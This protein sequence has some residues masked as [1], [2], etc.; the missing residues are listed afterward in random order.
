MRIN[1]QVLAVLSGAQMR[2]NTLVITQQLD[3]A[4]YTQ[5]NKVLEAAGGKWDRKA[6][7]HLFPSDAAERM[8]Q[9]ILTGEVTIPKDEFDYFPTPAAL[10]DRMVQ[11]AH[12]QR[13]SKVLEPSAGTGAILQALAKLDLAL[14]IVA[15]ELNPA[16]ARGL[17]ET[18][19]SGVEVLAQDFLAANKPM[20]VFDAVVM[21]PPFGKRADIHH[22]IHATQFLRPGGRLVAVMSAGVEFR[23]DRLATEFRA[24]VDRTHGSIERLPEGTFKPSGTGVNTVLVTL[25]K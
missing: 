3:R 10:A 1:D 13:C 4:L 7:A 18:F 8:D 6:K 16:M 12:L 5:T 20:P 9:I 24:M 22:V 25:T 2:G 17:K 15:V 19:G 14:E 21:N 23:Q 11:E